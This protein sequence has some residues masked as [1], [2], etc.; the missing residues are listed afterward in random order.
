MMADRIHRVA[1]TQTINAYRD[2][3]ERL[4]DLKQLEGRLE[5]IRRA[6]VQHHIELMAKRARIA[7]A[8]SALASCSP[9]RIS[10]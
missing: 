10:R 8:P 5:E 1:L 9:D 4:Q 3:P 6:N 7:C 2:M